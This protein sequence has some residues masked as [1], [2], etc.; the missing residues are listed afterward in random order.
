[1]LS[2]QHALASIQ[3]GRNAVAEVAESPTPLREAALEAFRRRNA[4]L[5][6]LFYDVGRVRSAEARTL[7]PWLA[8]EGS[9]LIVPPGDAG[10]LRLCADVDDFAAQ[11]GAG[12]RVLTVAGVGSSALGSAAFARNVAEAFAQPVAAVVSGYGLADLVTEAAGGLFWFGALNSM[13][14][15]FEQLDALAHA[16]RSAQLTAAEAAPAGRVSLDTR[17][18]AALLADPRFDFALLTGHSKGN[19]V[20]SE[21]LFAFDDAPAALRAGARIVTV[22]AAVAMPGRFAPVLDVMGA[23]DWFGALNSRPL[24]R[25]ETVVPMA[26]HHTNTEMPFHL[27]VTRVFRALRQQHVLGV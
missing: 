4:A 5:D 17:T 9:I 19:L 20:L 27:P 26:W 3:L 6:T 13:R 8:R 11:G 2:S 16:A 24:L 1:M 10:D 7:S 25:I 23:L 14:H 15:G 18:V 22:S 21:A 12:I